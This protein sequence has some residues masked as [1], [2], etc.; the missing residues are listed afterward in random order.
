[1][2]KLKVFAF[3]FITGTIIA[4]AQ[5]TETINSNRPGQSQGA[6][7]VGTG[8]YQL[9]A[10]GFYGNDTHELRQTDTDLYGANY[11]IRAGLLT[12]ILELSIKGRY[13][14]EETMIYQGG[15]N[16]TYERKNFP[17]NTIG[18]KVL[19]Y[20]PNKNGDNRREINIRSW[21]ANQK[22][23]WKRLIPAVS[24]YGGA[25]V[26]IQD[27]NP[28][29]FEGESK[30]TPQVTLITQHNWGRFVWVMNFT[31]EKFTETYDN[32]EFIGTLT[33]AFNPKF[34]IFG[35]YQAI[36]GDLYADD[37]FRAGGAYLIT[38]YL[39][40]DVAGLANVKDTPSRWQVQAG[41]SVR[42]NFHKDTEF[43]NLSKEGDQRRARTDQQYNF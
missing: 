5:F 7:A 35:E 28:Y 15:Q 14:V 22:F 39:Q 40:V 29:R 19:L 12:D 42:L 3:V 6:F 27:E 4:N 1:M 41:L 20:D 2:L 23:D 30:Y 25:N 26:T 37:I 13:Q 33:H 36:I 8:V 31:A 43:K 17:F 38:D 24:L 11:M 10:G 18:A 9:E 32:Y 16:R 34:A 21:D